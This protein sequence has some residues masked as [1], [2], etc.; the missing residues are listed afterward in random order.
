MNNDLFAVHS[1]DSKD[2]EL[3]IQPEIE[4]GKQLNVFCSFT[5]ITPNYSILFTLE[6]LKEFVKSGNYKVF[7]VMWDMNALANPYFKRLQAI[8]KIPNSEAF[9]NE[10]LQE[11]RDLAHSLGFNQEN[12][13][14]YKS[15]DLWK[16]LISYKEENLFQQFYSVIAQL[17]IKNYYV[18]D[19]ISHLI[20][21]PMDIFFCNY[22]HELYPE[23]LEHEIDI[24]YFGQNKE[25]LYKLTRE[26]MLESGI[27][28]HKNPLFVIMKNMPYLIKEDKVPEWNMGLREIKDIISAMELTKREI[29]D[30]FK[31]IGQNFTLTDEENK[32]TDYDYEKLYQLHKDSEVDILK[33]KLSENL[34]KYLQQR[35]KDFFKASGQVE[36]PILNVS[37]RQDVKN[38]GKVLKS[39]IALEILLKADGTRNTTKISK[40]L[41]KSIATISTYVNRLKR[42]NLIRVLEDG[43]LKRKVK[44]FKVN[45][46]LGV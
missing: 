44:G 13:Q 14:I 19:K 17:K 2:F 35:K 40:E 29:F 5:Y 36:E 30:L 11:L 38:V 34:F 46:E 20:Q 43:T 4:Q 12:L 42:L 23:D 37:T 6:E 9:I 21:I 39:T 27:I 26:L 32:D 24:A 1:D 33:M 7:I 41:G 22:F 31:H 3:K 15:S 16:R 45:L 18:S 25:S 28:S 8:K 10:K